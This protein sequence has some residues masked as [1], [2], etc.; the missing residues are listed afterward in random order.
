VE[1]CSYVQSFNSVF[2]GIQFDVLML[3]I[4]NY[5]IIFVTLVLFRLHSCLLFSFLLLMQPIDN[6]TMMYHGAVNVT[7]R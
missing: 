7:E 3:L 6:L 5:S 2:V 4:S 1:K